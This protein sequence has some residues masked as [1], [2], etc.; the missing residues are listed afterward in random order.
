MGESETPS[1]AER[2]V[3]INLIIAAYK[4]H[5]LTIGNASIFRD[6][7]NRVIGKRGFKLYR[8]SKPGGL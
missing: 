5:V 6:F 1:K 7:S 2:L 3:K 4:K 8:R